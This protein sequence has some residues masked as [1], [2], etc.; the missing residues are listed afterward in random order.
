[1]RESLA[2]IVRSSRLSNGYARQRREAGP[3]AGGRIAQ[4]PS[5]KIR[6]SQS[7]IQRAEPAVF[8]LRDEHLLSVS[9]GWRAG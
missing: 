2:K 5:P 4:R 3:D 9:S 6:L 8:I 7:A 1:V